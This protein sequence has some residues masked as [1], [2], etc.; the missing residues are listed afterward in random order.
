[1][2]GLILKDLFTLKKQM[3]VTLLISV[4]YIIMS[5]ATDNSG[6]LLTMIVLLCAMLPI[7]SMSYDEMCKWDKYALSMPISRK[8]LVW[9]KYLLGILF[10]MAGL[11]IVIPTNLIMTVVNGDMK[12]REQLMISLGVSGVALIYL[13]LILPILFKLGVEKGRILML[14]VFLVPMAVVFLVGKTHINLPSEQTI[15]RLLYLLP[16]FIIAL[17]IVS[18][19]ISV[20]IYEKKEF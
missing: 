10:D 19:L 1:M 8:T 17:L 16:I 3:K 2:K 20:R 9:S 7:S 4:F 6:M 11:L 12:M 15:N 5:V 18:I 14:A 13:A